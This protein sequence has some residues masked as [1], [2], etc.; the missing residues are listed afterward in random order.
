MKLNKTF[1]HITLIILLVI[2]S[3][4]LVSQKEVD[5]TPESIKIALRDAGNKVLLANDDAK[6]LVLPV[7]KLSESKYQLNFQKEISITP[8]RLVQIIDQSF[9]R[10]G[11]PAK[12]V[13]EVVQ[14]VDGEV[15]YSY[16]MSEDEQESIIPCN[17]RVLPLG[18]YSITAQFLNDQTWQLSSIASLLLIGL[19][20]LLLGSEFYKRK[21]TEQ[22]VA[23]DEDIITISDFLFFPNQ[24]KLTLKSKE[25]QLSR[26]EGELLSVLAS[27]L[28]IVVKREDLAKIWED[29]GVLVGRSLDTYISKLR[30]RLQD[31]QAIRLANVHGVGYKLEVGE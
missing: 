8:A 5:S 31:D 25:I 26:K 12:Y 1:L 18:C 3:I 15:A 27:N 22:K 7:K 30:K 20:L 2:S 14:C 17:N 10:S 6:S 11:L 29:N 24:N 4:F 28:N 23:N 13:V 16:Q 21:R 19:L 9:V